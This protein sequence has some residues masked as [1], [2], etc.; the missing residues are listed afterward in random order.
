MG[1][2]RHILTG[3]VSGRKLA[4]VGLV[5]LLIVVAL[6]QRSGGHTARRLP[7]ADE[8]GD[9]FVTE[10]QLR[11]VRMGM[12]ENGVLRLLDGEGSSG[13]YING[14]VGS[15]SVPGPQGLILLFEYPVRG[16][17][18]PRSNKTR[19]DSITWFRICVQQGRVIGERR[20]APYDRVAGCWR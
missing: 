13:F 10:T 16:M 6:Q 19:D 17:G 11:G 5:A 7:R 18:N 14:A 3:A 20:L 4:L 15:N 1:A 12:T 8:W 9:P 2:V